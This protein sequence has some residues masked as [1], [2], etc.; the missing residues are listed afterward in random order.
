MGRGH[1]V[2]SCA[3]LLSVCVQQTYSSFKLLFFCRKRNLALSDKKKNDQLL[4]SVNILTLMTVFS[5]LL[6]LNVVAK[7][8]VWMTTL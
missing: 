6:K 2:S 5:P 3:Q 8:L 7:R 4:R 1:I